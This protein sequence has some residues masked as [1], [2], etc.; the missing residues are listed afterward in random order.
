[1]LEADEM[2]HVADPRVDQGATVDE[3]GLVTDPGVDQGDERSLVADPGV[4]QGAATVDERSFV[5]DPGV[6]QGA[7][8]VDERSFVADPGVDQGAATVDKSFQRGQYGQQ[9]SRNTQSTKNNNIPIHL[10]SNKVSRYIGQSDC[11]PWNSATAISGE[12]SGVSTISFTSLEVGNK[13]SVDLGNNN[14][15]QN[16]LCEYTDADTSPVPN[17][18]RVD[19]GEP[20]PGRT[21]QTYRE[22]G[23]GGTTQGP[24]RRVSFKHFSC[25]KERWRPSNG[26]QFE[27]IESICTH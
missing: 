3:T 22:R 19:G 26:G 20:C 4:D 11:M 25:T 21:G 6:D 12:S 16:R 15:I 5:A 1:M 14:G 23:R 17:C 27:G 2:S 7:A 18:D 9:Q 8:T 24:Q 10:P 13:R